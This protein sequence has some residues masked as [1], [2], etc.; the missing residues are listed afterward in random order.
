[1]NYS[2]KN[3][4]EKASGILSSAAK[5][6][7]I[8]AAAAWFCSGF[9]HSPYSGTD[10]S[11]DAEAV[12]AEIPDTKNANESEVQHSTD[13]TTDVSAKPTDDG[14]VNP[15][16]G[17]LTSAFGSRRGR[18]HTGIDI[19]ADSGSDILAAA[20]GTVTFSGY[21][22]G[23]GN[24]LII[25]H[26]NGVQTAYGHCSKLIAKKGDAVKRGDKIACV[27]NTGNSTGPHLHF[28]IKINDEF[29]DPL[30]YVVY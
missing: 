1:M 28:E 29:V 6:L 20:D 30:D 15:A 18:R 13:D 25:D 8:L 16:C 12:T 23:Y 9:A 5:I 4:A 24:Y 26:G 21:A 7:F 17:V 14:F 11:V 10:T 3:S 27:G 19:G 22:D 2:R